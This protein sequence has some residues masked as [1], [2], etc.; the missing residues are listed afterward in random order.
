MSAERHTGREWEGERQGG[1][2]RSAADAP[3]PSVPNAAETIVV[4]DNFPHPV[5]VTRRELDVFE[6]YL[7][8][9]IDEV[10]GMKPAR[11]SAGRKVLAS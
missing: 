10:L 9:L 2:E 5:P 11:S 3:A 7:G 4:T 1:Q 6:T 8:A